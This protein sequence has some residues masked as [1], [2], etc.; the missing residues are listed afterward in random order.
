MHRFT[1]RDL[2]V[3]VMPTSAGVD[4]LDCGT[5]CTNEP[6]KDVDCG[7]ACT[8]EPTKDVDC[9]TAC[10]NEPTKADMWS[11]LATDADLGVLQGDLAL[12]QR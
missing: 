11:D 3:S 4:M 9:A 7:T 6:T 12:A 1:S 5:A 8:N 10:T 2:M